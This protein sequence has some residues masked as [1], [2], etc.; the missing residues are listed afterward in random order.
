M[1]ALLQKISL[2]VCITLLLNACEGQKNYFEI[3]EIFLSGPLLVLQSDC[4]NSISEYFLSRRLIGPGSPGT[5][6]V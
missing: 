1:P 2:L 5:S 4:L 6:L 3:K